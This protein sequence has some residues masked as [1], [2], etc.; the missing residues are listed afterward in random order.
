MA[1]FGLFFRTMAHR[2]PISSTDRDA[3]VA[4]PRDRWISTAFTRESATASASPA[5]S[6]ASSTSSTWRYSTP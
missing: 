3:R 2:S 4:Y 6:G 1:A 5:L